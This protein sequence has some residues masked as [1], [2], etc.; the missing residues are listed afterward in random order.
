MNNILSTGHWG[1]GE[2]G[3]NMLLIF[4]L[5]LLVA[6]YYD[7]ALYNIDPGDNLA[8]ETDPF[9]EPLYTKT[10]C[11]VKAFYNYIIDN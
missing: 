8:K 11:S 4:C 10:D 1:V 9:F 3:N 6:S 5:Q 2:F 7:V